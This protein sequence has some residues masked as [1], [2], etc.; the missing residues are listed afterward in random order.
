MRSRCGRR[1]HRRTEGRRRQRALIGPTAILHPAPSASPSARALAAGVGS[2]QP[3]G[4]LIAHLEGEQLEV[5]RANITSSRRARA[6][7]GEMPEVWR[8]P[9]R[10]RSQS[11]ATPAPGRRRRGAPLRSHSSPL[12][13]R[14]RSRPSPA[15]AP[16]DAGAPVAPVRPSYRRT[17]VPADARPLE[18]GAPATAPPRRRRAR[19]GARRSALVSRHAPPSAHARATRAVNRRPGSCARRTSVHLAAQLATPDER[20][21]ARAESPACHPV[22]R[23]TTA[24]CDAIPPPIRRQC[25]PR[26]TGREVPATLRTAREEAPAVAAAL[27]LAYRDRACCWSRRC[28]Y[29]ALARRAVRHGGRPIPSSGGAGMRCALRTRGADVSVSAATRSPSPPTVVRVL[30]PA[31]GEVTA[32]RPSARPRVPVTLPRA[33]PRAG[34]AL[35]PSRHLG[36][37]P[38]QH[39]RSWCQRPSAPAPPSSTPLPS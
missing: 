26:M 1:L 31:C 28:A 2:L 8:R 20:R 29:C 10:N 30:R 34:R 23:R 21:R 22:R 6:G 32:W 5:D 37:D 16:A 13:L 27:G 9:K 12:P 15:P 18:S 11:F 39:R 33:S 24:L 35:P 25:L 36:D 14:S 19:R 17:P 38:L 7:L 4:I 3:R